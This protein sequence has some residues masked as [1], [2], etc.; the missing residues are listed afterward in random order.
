M[1]GQGRKPLLRKDNVVYRL[2]VLPD[3]RANDSRVASAYL[4]EC[5]NIH[6][7]KQLRSFVKRWKALWELFPDTTTNPYAKRLSSGR[8]PYKHVFKKLAKLN[9]GADFRRWSDTLALAMEL[10]V[11]GSL[12]LAYRVSQKYGVTEDVVIVQ[13]HRAVDLL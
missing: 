13:A 4:S 12:L 8:V 10:R 7:T 1:T 6:S 5:K 11:P 2:P 9:K 3:V